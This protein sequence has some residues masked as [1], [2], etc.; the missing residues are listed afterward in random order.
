M[1]KFKQY[2]NESYKEYKFRIKTIVPLDSAA[3][4]KIEYVLNKYDMTDISA[5]RETPIQEIPLE[6]YEI[7]NTS[8][9]IIDAVTSMPIAPHILLQQLK[10]ILDIPEKFIVVRGEN[11]PIE[12]YTQEMKD[13]ADK[14]YIT[15][16]STDPDYNDDE[17]SD[18]EPAFGDEY[19]KK[20][21]SRIARAKHVVETD[22]KPEN[23]A[24][25]KDHDGVKPHYG[26]P[27]K[28]A[29]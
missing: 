4:D 22:V 19:N 25:N 2:L 20:F 15:K 27:D 7:Q 10:D 16:L 1:S 28:G 13:K 8:V 18:E 3:M 29:K 11:D 6:F 12:I 24:F 26:K 21:L 17:K 5:P 14:P 9:F 23:A